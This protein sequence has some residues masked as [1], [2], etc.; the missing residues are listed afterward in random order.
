MILSVWMVCVLIARGSGAG[1][2]IIPISEIG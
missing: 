2:G 1:G